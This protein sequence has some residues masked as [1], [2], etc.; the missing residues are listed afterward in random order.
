MNSYTCS[1]LERCFPGSTSGKYTTFAGNFSFLD[2]IFP[3]HFK[4]KVVQNTT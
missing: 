3:L 2:C 4:N 1:S